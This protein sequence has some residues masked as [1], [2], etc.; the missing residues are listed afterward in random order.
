MDVAR[1]LARSAGC[2][3]LSARW[4]VAFLLFAI[5]MLAGCERQ[6]ATE[7]AS[8]SGSVD[9]VRVAVTDFAAVAPLFVAVAEGFPEKEG[10]KFSVQRYASGKAAM[11]AM[12]DGKADVATVA[13]M[14]IALAAVKGKPIVVLAT[15]ANGEDDYG[16]VARRDR[17]IT[18]AVALKGKRIALTPGTGGDYFL[19][20]LLIRQRLSRA[21]VQV[22]TLAP[23]ELV[24][25]L[26]D[27]RIDAIS[28]WE[29][30]LSTARR[31]LGPNAASFSSGGIYESTF[32]LVATR[33]FANQ[34]GQAVKKLI[35]TLLRAEVFLKNE[36]A[37]TLRI[38]AAELKQPPAETR[39]LLS[40]HRFMVSL[41]QSLILMMEDE[42]RWM[43]RQRMVESAAL[44]NFLDHI[45]ISALQEIRPRAVTI[46]R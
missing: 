9:T 39:E 29:P 13:D 41:D 34:R 38:M 2:E 11:E 43:I 20:A 10:L 15:F 16:V 8:D 35:K 18:D 7:T 30:Y 25:A 33:D 31:N 42:A 4:P 19:D 12:L 32:N 36:S 23:P 45:S 3:A 1:L 6:A 37:T 14:P 24:P 40:K 17:G 28:T 27:G 21:D 22:T 46:I 44:P 5:A 26:E